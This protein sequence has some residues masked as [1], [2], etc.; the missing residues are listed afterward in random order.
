MR[1]ALR[2]VGARWV[3][4][5]LVAAFAVA[6]AYALPFIPNSDGW[7]TLIG[8]VVVL[9]VAEVRRLREHRAYGAIE[10]EG[11]RAVDRAIRTGV[12]PQ[13]PTLEMALLDA[14]ETRRGV[15]EKDRS[16]SR[17]FFGAMAIISVVAGAFNPL[18]FGF[19][20]VFLWAAATHHIGIDRS[21]A[22]LERLTADVV[23]PA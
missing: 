3:P 17:W 23:S 6:T 13:D 8:I 12:A 14:I 11:W 7:S 20:A 4:W 5:C 19:A 1:D 18:Y 16:R 22:R 21:L 10:P 15:L 2:E 9:G